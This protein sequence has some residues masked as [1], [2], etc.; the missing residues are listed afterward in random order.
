[1]QILACSLLRNRRPALAVSRL[2]A[3]WKS[4]VPAPSDRDPAGET[5]RDIVLQFSPSVFTKQTRGPIVGIDLCWNLYFNPLRFVK[6]T[7]GPNLSTPR[8]HLFHI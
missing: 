5:S 2:M 7:Q 1:M 4:V 6:Q 3:G 8:V